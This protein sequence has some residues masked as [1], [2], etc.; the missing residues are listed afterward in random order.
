MFVRGGALTLSL[1]S[2]SRPPRVPEQVH[3]TVN[4]AI[5]WNIYIT[6]FF[7]LCMGWAH[8]IMWIV[9][10]RESCHIAWCA[11]N[12][13][14]LTNFIDCCFRESWGSESSFTSCDALWCGATPTSGTERAREKERLFSQGSLF[15]RLFLKIWNIILT[16][17]GMLDS[18]FIHYSCLLSPL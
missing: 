17:L 13:L 3:R 12:L 2:H 14:L 9:L 16:S 10:Q 11:F 6:A 7:C 18:T 1:S 4:H 8:S 5:H 15:F